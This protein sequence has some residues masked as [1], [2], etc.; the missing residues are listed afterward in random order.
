ME[1]I[2]Q[3]IVF[4][5]NNPDTHSRK[6]PTRELSDREIEGIEGNIELEDEVKRELHQ[7]VL[8]KRILVCHC[9]DHLI[10][11]HAILHFT[12]F[13]GFKQCEQ[14]SLFLKAEA[15]HEIED[16][17]KLLDLIEQEAVG[18][19][20]QMLIYTWED[21][22]QNI[23]SFPAPFL[24]SLTANDNWTK[25]V[26][27][28][29]ERRNIYLVY[30]TS[31]NGIHRHLERCKQ[32]EGF[33]FA[34]MTVDY[35]RYRLKMYCR[36]HGHSDDELTQIED[37]IRNQLS[38]GL[39]GENIGEREAFEE[40]KD[41]MSTSRLRERLD[42]KESAL[43]LPQFTIGP[44]P[45]QEG[46]KL[47]N[48]PDH[49]H[50]VLLFMG[51]YFEGI[52]I[53]PFRHV[54][55]LLISN[56][57]VR[58]KEE[59]D[60]TN[61]PL[62]KK[63]RKNIEITW[64][65]RWK[66][67]ADSYLHEV[68]LQAKPE[69]DI[70]SKSTRWIIGFLERKKQE[71]TTQLVNAKYALFADRQI[72]ILIQSGLIHKDQLSTDLQQRFIGVL[73][74]AA[75]TDPEGRGLR[76]FESFDQAIQWE[77]RGD[78]SGEM[79]LSNQ[80]LDMAPPD[81]AENDNGANSQSRIKVE[82]ST[83]ETR[84]VKWMVLVIERSQQKQIILRYLEPYFKNP[85][86]HA[87]LSKIF[88]YLGI[89]T[90]IDVLKQFRLF[91]EINAGEFENR[92]VA[93]VK[94]S[95][96]KVLNAMIIYYWGSS[97]NWAQNFAQVGRWL[98]SENPN[99]KVQ[100]ILRYAASAFVLHILL[101]LSGFAMKENS[102]RTSFSL[103]QVIFGSSGKNPVRDFLPII[104]GQPLQESIREAINSTAAA[105][106]SHGKTTAS[107]SLWLKY[108]E[109]PLDVE[110]DVW[111]LLLLMNGIV[112]SSLNI[113][114]EPQAKDN[115]KA[116][117]LQRIIDGIV[118]AGTPPQLRLARKLIPQIRR[119][120][121]QQIQQIKMKKVYVDRDLRDLKFLKTHRDKAE[122]TRK[123]LQDTFTQNSIKKI[124]DHEE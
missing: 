54:A 10:F 83:L 55:K 41:L 93:R 116:Q 64:T 111:P 42:A 113:Q 24:K 87:L 26:I 9:S 80:K 114:E 16:F 81:Q 6:D 73:A 112:S 102:L 36:R 100:S 104:L 20:R 50:K 49:I 56:K 31:Q 94:Y 99:P 51:T 18:R 52:S 106:K 2:N 19:G 75:V 92:E 17:S 14:R 86:R 103:F 66:N 70:F 29:L 7:A 110:E 117:M 13:D 90:D 11:K 34:H 38:Q 61:K 8:E 78:S 46:G 12:E 40:L 76:I 28:E 33:G 58:E 85:G 96:G 118:A 15:E 124:S 63:K 5:Y 69:I 1:V 23:P 60:R 82:F 59:L 30:F 43:A 79:K 4:H 77:N 84:M 45:E 27:D 25:N 123:A 39:W 97:G 62:K 37:K 89:H 120:C 88:Q 22:P 95:L 53:D 47:S 48:S 108:A 21:M 122:I 72:D 109:Y 65:E 74:D 107:I 91:L 68:G 3:T 44:A 105:L 67:N 119:R 71:A 101:A 121:N 35:L 115:P 32:L 98:S 57:D